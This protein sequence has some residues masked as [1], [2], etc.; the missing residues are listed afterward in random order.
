M[1]DAPKVEDG[2]AAATQ[3]WPRVKWPLAAY[4]AHA[5]ER[6]LA[7]P[8]DLYLAGAAGYRLDTAWYEINGEVAKRCQGV[9]Q[10]KGWGDNQEQRQTI[11]S[12][13]IDEYIKPAGDHPR[14]PDGQYPTRL[15]KYG[16]RCALVTYICNLARLR[17]IDLIRESQRGREKGEAIASS[18]VLEAFAPDQLDPQLA[19]MADRELAKLLRPRVKAAWRQ[20]SEQQQ[21]LLRLLLFKGIQKQKAGRVLGLEPW[22]VTRAFDKIQK[23]MES[24]FDRVVEKH[25]V[26]PELR[27]EWIAMW[28][29]LCS[30]SE[31]QEN[32]Q[33]GPESTSNDAEDNPAPETGPTAPGDPDA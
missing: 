10:S 32:P 31:N 33:A 15:I 27:R 13:V 12:D 19:K 4:T 11:W 20:M 14:L 16:G 30:E 8:C 6:S 7:H 2:F 23:I 17:A 9:F 25:N 26:S 29:E 22:G 24:T 5:A 3:R 28:N 18:P 21:S 1:E